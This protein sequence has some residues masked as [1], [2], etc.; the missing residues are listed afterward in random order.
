MLIVALVLMVGLSAVYI[1][2]R[3]RNKKKVLVFKALATLVADFLALGFAW[4]SGRTLAWWFAAGIFFY[5]CADVVL[6]FKFLH[7]MALF[8]AGHVCLI[9]GMMTEV[10]IGVDTVVAFVLLFGTAV[11]LFRRYL[12]KMKRLLPAAAGYVGVLC[13]MSSMAISMA[14]RNVCAATVLRAIGSV[15]FVISDW[16]IGWNFLRRKRTKSSGVLL[17]TL[18]YVALYLLA[19]GLY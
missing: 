8:A 1:A 19:A 5:A 17:L 15:C 13:L 16:I 2:G 4:Q 7:G 6:E 9:A 3:D 12:P 18:Y 11:W 10:K 14:V